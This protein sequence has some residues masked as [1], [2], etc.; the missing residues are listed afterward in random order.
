MKVTEWM[1]RYRPLVQE[2]VK[3]ENSY[4]RISSTKAMRLDDTSFVSSQ[5]WQVLEYLLEHDGEPN[6]MLT[7]A[8]TLGIAPSSLSKITKSLISCGLI[9]RYR[10]SNNKKNVILKVTDYGRE[11]YI[12]NAKKYME[13]VF[14]TLF[15]SLREIPDDYLILFVEALKNFNNRRK[16]QESNTLIK[17][18][19]VKRKTEMR[20]KQL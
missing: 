19:D 16:T 20:E 1:G 4:S 7:V 6:N 18:E 13:P 3:Y 9:E 2:L 12:V 15:D 8:D 11:R 17:I 14:N 10:F 5:E